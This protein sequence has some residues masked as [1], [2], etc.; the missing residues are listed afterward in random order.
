MSLNY[1]SIGGNDYFPTSLDVTFTPANSRVC[2]NISIVDDSIPESDE[3][4]TVVIEPSSGVN[5]GI[6]SRVNI[7]DNDGMSDNL[8]KFAKLQ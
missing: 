7:I 1:N 4:F 3:I 2:K 5:P 8:K 6:D